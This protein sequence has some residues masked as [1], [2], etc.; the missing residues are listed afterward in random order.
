MQAFLGSPESG[1]RFKRVLR[2]PL[3]ASQSQLELVFHGGVTGGVTRVQK[4]L[5]L[6][7]IGVAEPLNIY[8]NNMLT[9]N[10]SDENYIDD[11][12]IYVQGTENTN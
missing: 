10:N 8:F 2:Q 11:V 6:S 3:D 1:S 9:K 4:T 5:D 12:K 7:S